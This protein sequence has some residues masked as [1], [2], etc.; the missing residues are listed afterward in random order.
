MQIMPVFL[1]DTIA[2]APALML[3]L[4]RGT[5]TLNVQDPDAPPRLQYNFLCDDLDLIRLRE[6]VRVATALGQD[7]A[8]RAVLSEQLAPTRQDLSS[9]GAL[10]GWLRAN[11]VTGYAS[12]GT[13]KM[14]DSTDPLSVVDDELRVHGVENLAIADLSVMPD[15]VSA[16]TNA[17]AI[18]IGERASELLGHA[19]PATAAAKLVESPAWD[20]NLGTP[21]PE[22]P[23]GSKES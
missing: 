10:D 4:S 14:G 17:T 5:L 13:C 6:G 8:L 18:M 9:D 22:V 20:S 16:N 21:R 11:V 3:P 23:S 12:S 15:T 19:T 2:L 1:P 7:P